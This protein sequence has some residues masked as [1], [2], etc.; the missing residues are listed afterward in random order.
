MLED[1]NETLNPGLLSRQWSC[2][3]LLRGHSYLLDQGDSNKKK[4][5]ED[6]LKV[7][8]AKK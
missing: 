2:S 6:V 5:F 4:T 7:P 8:L 3:S 1:T